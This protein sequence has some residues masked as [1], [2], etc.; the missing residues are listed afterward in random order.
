MY[1]FQDPPLVLSEI[2]K[3]IFSLGIKMKLFLVNSSLRMKM[4]PKE[5]IREHKI[6]LNFIKKT[7][8]D[9]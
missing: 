5:A 8:Y 1:I 7:N 3:L 4:V 2:E 9:N 6:Y